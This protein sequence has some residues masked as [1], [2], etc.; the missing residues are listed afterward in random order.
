MLG[1]GSEYFLHA[2]M[3]RCPDTVLVADIEHRYV[4]D[5]ALTAEQPDG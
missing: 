5:V 4:L 2:R 3:N 1:S